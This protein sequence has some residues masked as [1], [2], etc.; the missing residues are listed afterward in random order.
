[1]DASVVAALDESDAF[2][3]LLGAAGR[4][5][6]QHAEMAG[7]DVAAMF[8]SL[9]QFASGVYPG[10]LGLVD[11]V[12]AGCHEARSQTLEAPRRIGGCGGRGAEPV[13]RVG[14]C[15]WGTCAVHHLRGGVEGVARARPGASGQYYTVS[16]LMRRWDLRSEAQPAALGRSPH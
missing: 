13:G 1:M 12:L 14:A 9:A 7:G 15:G 8:I 10:Q 3:Q 16:C 2:G 5:A 6:A 11:R 4:V